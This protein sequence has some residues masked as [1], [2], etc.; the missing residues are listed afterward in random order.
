MTLTNVLNEPDMII[1]III[2]WNIWQYLLLF[3]ITLCNIHN[4][5][6]I[7][8]SCLW[9]DLINVWENCK[10]WQTLGI[11][12]YNYVQVEKGKPM[13]LPWVSDI[14]TCWKGRDGEYTF[15]FASWKFVHWI[16]LWDLIFIFM[17]VRIFCC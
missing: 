15:I 14:I 2:S 1:L 9:N 17:T 6:V 4:I 12:F 3:Y 8:Y 16:I 11:L 10:C 7:I 13:F 5:H